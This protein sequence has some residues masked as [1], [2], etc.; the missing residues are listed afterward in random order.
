MAGGG[1]YGF[2][3]LSNPPTE[4]YGD[5][6]YEYSPPC[7]GG[8]FAW[9]PASNVTSATHAYPGCELKVE[10]YFLEIGAAGG[11][12]DG[13]GMTFMLLTHTGATVPT[14]GFQF[15]LVSTSNESL[16]ASWV[17]TGTC[18]GSACSNE[19]EAG[20]AIT[21]STGGTASLLGDNVVAVGVG[22]AFQGEVSTVGGLPA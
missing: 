6:G 20:D 9:G 21:L 2:V 4:C 14:T 1:L 7:Y 12:I 5:L 10:C 22:N 11:G 19:I 17:S 8:L 18:T 3:V 13:D 15:G 16:S